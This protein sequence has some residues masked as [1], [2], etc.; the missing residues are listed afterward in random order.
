MEGE[1]AVAASLHLQ[2]GDNVQRRG[3]EHLIFLI[4]Q[5]DGG[6]DDDAVT[7]MNPYGI[8]V[9]HAAHRNDVAPAVPHDL[10]FDFLPAG[11]AFFHQNLMDG[12]KPQTVAGDFAQFLRR[13]RDAAAAAAQ[14]EGGADDDRI[15][16][17]L[18]KGH[19]CVQIGDNL[20]GN[21]R[22][23][24]G[25][26]GILEQ[27]AVLR[28]VDGF[29]AGAQQPDV[30]LLQETLLRQ[31]H[32]QSQPRLPSQG[33]EQAVRLLLFDDALDNIQGQRLD[34]NF[35]CHVLIGHDGS[36]VGVDK[37]HLQPFL[38]QRAAGLGTGIVELGGLADDNGAG[39]DDH[40]LMDC[41]I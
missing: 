17:F 2:G 33:G 41:G 30:V 36:G 21:H 6:S 19:G 13:F 24:D 9:F 28:L 23:T 35:I 14:G 22:L 8:E 40:H 38:L 3:A 15:T 4:R 11:D 27:L 25:F 29:R 20:G 5:G 26:H 12:G 32:G 37:H 7:G 39:T 1:L 10:E 34:I 31:L 18:R 16:D